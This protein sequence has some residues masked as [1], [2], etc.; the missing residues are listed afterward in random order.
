MSDLVNGMLVQHASLGIG[1]VVAVE[2]TA[3]HVFFPESEK[4]Y[5]AKLRWPVA[6]P[7]LKTEGVERDAWLAELSSFSFDETTGRYALP[8]NWLTH[9][10]AI[11]DFLGAFPQGFADP[12]YVGS[13][14]GR[15]GRAPRWRA[16]QAEWAKAFGDGEGERLLAADDLRELVGRTLRVEEHLTLVPVPFEPG[17]PKEALREPEATRAFFEAL[18]GL[19]S[20]PSPGRARHE[21][22]FAA[23]AGLGLDPGL[24]W[25]AATVLP[26]IADPTRHVLLWPRSACAAAERLGFDL[27]F[28]STPNWTT[29]T[30]LR[31]FSMRLLESLKANGA[32]DFIDVEAF[33]QATVARRAP[34]VKGHGP[35]ANGP[36]GSRTTSR[37]PPEGGATPGSRRKR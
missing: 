10:Q 6:R 27:R 13:A 36:L 7:L 15:R 37:P 30:A 29:Y 2:A 9:G 33:L 24:A 28:D 23:T 34:A 16:A 14:T 22:L 31:G 4:R 3:V 17:A 26:F 1:K 35:G 32:R 18:L 5:A 20:V 21:R 19:L 25:P 12:A 11:A 8:A